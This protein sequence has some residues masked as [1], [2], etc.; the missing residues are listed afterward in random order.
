VTSSSV[1][2]VRLPDGRYLIAHL[3]PNTPYQ[4]SPLQRAL[5]AAG[6][7]L[8]TKGLKGPTFRTGATQPGQ[9]PPSTSR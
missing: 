1:V 3:D 8:T 9:T 5:T 6:I 2:T 4:H 7:P